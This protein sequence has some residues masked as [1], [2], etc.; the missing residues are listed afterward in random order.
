MTEEKKAKNG[1][2]VRSLI[3]K[4]STEPLSNRALSSIGKALEIEETRWQAYADELLEPPYSPTALISLAEQCEVLAQCVETYEVNIDG[5]GYVIRLRPELEK[6]KIKDE[7]KSEI[8]AERMMLH[9]FF[10]TCSLPL[11]FTQLRRKTR[12]DLE[13]TGNAYWEVLESVSGQ[14]TGFAHIPPQT[15]RLTA[16]E[17]EPVKIKEPVVVYKDGKPVIEERMVYRRFRKYAQLTDSGDVIWFKEFGDP[18]RLNYKTGQFGNNVSESE[19][20]NSIIHFRV[21]SPRSP[22]GIPRWIGALLSVLGTRMA[23]EINYITFDNNCIPSAILMISGGYLTDDSVDRVQQWLED[24]VAGTRS[25]STILLLEAE[26]FGADEFSN[27]A[28]PKMQLEEIKTAQKDDALFKDYI[29]KNRIRIRSSFRLPA[30][31]LGEGDV[32]R[33]S[34]EAIRRVVEEQ[35]FQPERESFDFLMSNLILPRLGARFHIFQ[36]RL[37]VITDADTLA[38][39]AAYLE[40]AGGMTPEIARSILETILNRDLPPVNPDRLDPETPMT[41]Q[42]AEAAKKRGEVNQG[43]VA[44][45]KTPRMREGGRL[46]ADLDIESLRE[47][48]NRYLEEV[49]LEELG[50]LDEEE[51]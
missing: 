11:S 47:R 13:L 26:P 6:S 10:R 29:E 30:F 32:S 24:E 15:V 25:R 4:N 9:D 5:F 3:I 23:D 12:K 27:P 22:Y 20:A 41:I 35:V 36:S 17:S 37:P 28:V 42:V 33:A 2:G 49:E 16:K 46:S 39:S 14:I 34:A 7:L 38:R 31:M 1:A 18:R 50:V 45:V 19:R 8:E 48:L 44:P 40:K 21:Y 51:S 43:S